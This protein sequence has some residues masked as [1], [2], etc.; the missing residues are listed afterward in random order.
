[1][2]YLQQIHIQVHIE[3]ITLLFLL[4]DY[5]VE[6]SGSDCAPHHHIV[7]LVLINT[8][9]LILFDVLLLASLHCADSLPKIVILLT[10]LRG[11]E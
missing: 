8:H 3:T 10:V 5:V 4:L 6:V 7:V 11:I 1:M 2:K 9:L